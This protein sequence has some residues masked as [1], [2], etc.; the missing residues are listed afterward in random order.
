MKERPLGR[1]G[2]E[3]M[4]DSERQIDMAYLLDMSGGDLEFVQEIL[5]TFLETS[6]DLLAGIDDAARKGD[7]TKAVYAAH[8]LKGSLRSIG[9]EPL[10]TLCNDLEQTARVGDMAVFASMSK[11]VAEGF[12]LLRAE[13]DAVDLKEAA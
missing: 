13:I 7:A 9:A 12:K 2:F 4:G 10:A 11:H 3:T 5:S 6:G 8:T 1:D